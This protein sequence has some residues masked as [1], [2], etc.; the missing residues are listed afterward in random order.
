[1]EITPDGRQD[2]FLEWCNR[3]RS[4]HRTTT[5]LR[6]PWEGVPCVLTE[7]GLVLVEVSTQGMVCQ[8]RWIFDELGIY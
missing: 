5:R 4:V 8:D 6:D 7:D 1:M 2:C 3:G